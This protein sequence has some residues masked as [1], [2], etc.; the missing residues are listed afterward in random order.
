LGHE[1]KVNINKNKILLTLG[2]EGKVNGHV[3]FCFFLILGHEGKLSD[4]NI[5]VKSG[6]WGKS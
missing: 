4:Q 2:H 5:A 6:A 1:R 3:L